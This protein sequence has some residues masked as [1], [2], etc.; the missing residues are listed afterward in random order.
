MCVITNTYFDTY[1]S[2]FHIPFLLGFIQLAIRVTFGLM[3]FFTVRS[4]RNRQTPIVRLERDKQITT[5][6][7]NVQSHRTLLHRRRPLLGSRRDRRRRDPLRAV[8]HLL[9]LQAFQRHHQ[10]C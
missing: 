4:L 2:R 6:V 1:F 10:C 8:L 9:H 5:M 3:A 7:W